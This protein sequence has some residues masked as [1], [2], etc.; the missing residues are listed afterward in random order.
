MTNTNAYYN[1]KVYMSILRTCMHTITFQTLKYQSLE[2]PTER[3]KKGKRK[4]LQLQCVK[5]RQGNMQLLE[6]AGFD[7][8]KSERLAISREK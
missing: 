3:G 6:V 7:Q 8:A 1:L 5:G 2:T 4:N